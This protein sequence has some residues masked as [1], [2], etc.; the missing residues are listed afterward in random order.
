MDRK[1][2]QKWMLGGVQ[3]DPIECPNCMS[4]YREK[5]DGIDMSDL[6]QFSS[7]MIGK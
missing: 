4:L 3:A 1:G 7:V 6:W 5:E 2:H